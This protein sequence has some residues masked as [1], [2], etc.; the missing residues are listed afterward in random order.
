MTEPHA[1]EGRV[2]QPAVKPSSG[3]RPIPRWELGLL[4]LVAAAT[5]AGDQATKYLVTRFLPVGASWAPIP[6]LERWFTLTHTRNAGASFGL[7]PQLAP[8][9]LAISTVVV[10]GI[11]VYARFL[12]PGD[13]WMALSLGLMLGGALGNL[14]DRLR[15]G[16]VVDFLDFKVW[17]VFNCADSAIVIGVACLLWLLFREPQRHPQGEQQAHADPSSPADDD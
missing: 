11:V 15:I 17:P 6:A 14:V 8:L 12:R 3:A 4:F 5:F 7:F 13:R 9:F 10:V 1:A 16:H 2:R